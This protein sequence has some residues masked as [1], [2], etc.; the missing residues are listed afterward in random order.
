LPKTASELRARFLS[1]L[2]YDKIWKLKGQ[3]KKPGH[4][5]IVVFD[6]DD[7]LICT[8]ALQ[9]FDEKDIQ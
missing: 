5:N 3:D 9:P 2:A 4:Q 1:K 7:T 8:S 6:W